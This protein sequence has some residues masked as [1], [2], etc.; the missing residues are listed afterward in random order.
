MSRF[1]IEIRRGGQIIGGWSLGDEPLEFCIYEGAEEALKLQLS[2]PRRS[3]SSSGAQMLSSLGD[4]DDFT[5]PLPEG[6]GDLP[7]EISE[8]DQATEEAE[9]HF[10]RQGRARG[11]NPLYGIAR[12]NNKSGSSFNGSSHLD[13]EEESSW[14]S[15]S[16]AD[17]ATVPLSRFELLQRAKQRKN[18]SS[19]FEDSS[20]ISGYVGGY[21]E[22]SFDDFSLPAIIEPTFDG[23]PELQDDIQEEADQIRSSLFSSL[24]ADDEKEASDQIEVLPAVD[25]EYSDIFRSLLLNDYPAPEDVAQENEAEE[26]SLSDSQGEPLIPLEV[27]SFN[28]FRWELLGSLPAGEQTIV[29]DLTVRYHRSGLMTVDGFSA[30]SVMIIDEIGQEQLYTPGLDDPVPQGGTI[31]LRK[32]EDDAICIRPP[33]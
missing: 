9:Y 17:D 15:V 7:A 1:R 24:H 5:L 31:M 4:S 27:W 33:I 28:G 14:D 12:E 30:A 8:N 23:I 32:D 16:D 13:A 3:T 2:D 22:D 11:L 29:F 6:I 26:I 21:Q 19:Q 18:R 10:Q 25:A 20:G